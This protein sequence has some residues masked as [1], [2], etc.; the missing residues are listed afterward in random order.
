MSDSTKPPAN[1]PST[2]TGDIS[3]EN[4]PQIP[5][6]KFNEDV[7]KNKVILLQDLKLSLADEGRLKWF[8]SHVQPLLDRYNAGEK[9]ESLFNEIHFIIETANYIDP[10]GDKERPQ[11]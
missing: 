1:K 5:K 8:A 9:S 4:A 3:K 11:L 6:P 7:I 2:P 10:K